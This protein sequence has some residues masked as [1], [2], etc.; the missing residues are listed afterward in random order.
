M[1]ANVSF[2]LLIFHPIGWLLMLM[3]VAVESLLL[4]KL[5]VLLKQL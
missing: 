3:V 1:L 5:L 4:S 2:G